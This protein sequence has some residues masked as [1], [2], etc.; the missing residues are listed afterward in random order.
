MPGTTDQSWATVEVL[1]ADRFQECFHHLEVYTC[2]SATVQVFEPIDACPAVCDCQNDPIVCDE[3]WVYS[4][5]TCECVR[6]PSPI[7]IDIS[8]NGFRLTSSVEGVSFDLDNSGQR[9][10]VSWT[11]PNSD[12]AWLAYDRN[13]NGVIDNGAELFG[14]FTPQ[15]ASANRNGFLAL[16]EYDKPL[17]GGNSDGQIDSRDAIFSRLRLWQDTNH[18]GVSEPN[19]LHLLPELEVYA[20]ELRY[21]ESQRTD[22]YG[23]QFKYRAKVK[24]ERRAQL[25]KW[26]WEVFLLRGN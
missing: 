9:E 22:Q 19:E 18:N 10:L 14:N 24:D 7:L 12:D 11:A 1:N 17:R 13:G 20:I 23:N 25:G 3:G 8:G 5:T 15:P 6:W 16:A 2:G 21:K 26:A 4:F